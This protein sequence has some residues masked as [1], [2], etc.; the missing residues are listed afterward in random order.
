MASAQRYLLSLKSFSLLSR[1][2]QF[3]RPNSG[4]QLADHHLPGAI[5]E[6]DA[7]RCYVTVPARAP[8]EEMKRASV[9]KLTSS[10]ASRAAA[11]C[12]GP[13]GLS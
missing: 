2:Y 7:L 3:P 9:R 10:N 12:R 5:P 4:Y 13:A 6:V 1:R 8:S 11:K